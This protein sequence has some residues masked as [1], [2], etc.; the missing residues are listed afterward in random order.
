MVPLS[1]AV[2]AKPALEPLFRPFGVQPLP[3]ALEEQ[4][5]LRLDETTISHEVLVIDGAERVA[6]TAG[7]PPVAKTQPAELEPRLKRA[8]WAGAVERVARLAVAPA[9]TAPGSVS[10]MFTD[11]LNNFLPGVQL[12]LLNEATGQRYDATT[13]RSGDFAISDLPVGQYRLTASLPGFR[14]TTSILTVRSGVNTERTVVMAIGMVEETITVVDDGIAAA[15]L[16]VYQ[17]RPTPPPPP[18]TTPGI[19]GNLRPP[20]KLRHVAPVY[21]PSGVEGVVILAAVISLDGTVTNTRALS[22]PDPELAQ[23]AMDAVNLWEFDP[24]LLDG[25]TVDT[26][27]QVTVSFSK[28]R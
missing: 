20:R 22:S 24:T 14:E 13:G 21:P 27:M 23:A 5:G 25:V 7:V 2:T 4:L 10:G 16:P 3:K 19:G 12:T 18:Q 1:I 17:R 8:P 26:L 6:S 11:Q 28:P 15:A 9:Q